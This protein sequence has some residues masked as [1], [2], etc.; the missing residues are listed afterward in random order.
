MV[1]T[2]FVF[3]YAIGFFFARDFACPFLSVFFSIRA[4]LQFSNNN[5]PLVFGKP[6]ISL[7]NHLGLSF[8]TSL[9]SWPRTL[10]VYAAF[11]LKYDFFVWDIILSINSLCC[12]LF[13]LAFFFASFLSARLY[14]ASIAI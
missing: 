5:R 8:R 10:E 3:E 12:S 1:S 11:L 13:A 9:S 6:S 2:M 14:V 7:L 4:P